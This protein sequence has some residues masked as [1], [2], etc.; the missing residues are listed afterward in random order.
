MHNMKNEFLLTIFLQL[1]L[2]LTFAKGV[3]KNFAKL[4]RSVQKR[5]QIKLQYWFRLDDPLQFSNHL[6]G[7]FPPHY[8]FRIGEYRVIGRMENDDFV[9]I[10]IGH[11]REIYK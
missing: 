3:S 5:I 8:R 1:M 7:Y 6:V 10:A 4:E 2:N 9:V 11:R